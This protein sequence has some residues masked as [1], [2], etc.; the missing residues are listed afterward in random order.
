MLIT[1]DVRDFAEKHAVN[2]RAS[3]S[4]SGKSVED[5]RRKEASDDAEDDDDEDEDASGPRRQVCAPLS[6]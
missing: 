5:S 6:L 4:K 1:E 3:R 2:E